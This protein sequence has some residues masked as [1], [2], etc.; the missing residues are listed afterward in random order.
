MKRI[1]RRYLALHLDSMVSPTRRE[2]I[3]AIWNSVTK[4]YGE[5]GASLANLKLIDYDAEKKIAVIRTALTSLGMVRTA[6][7]SITSIS[8]KD[9]AVHVRSVS[10]TIKSLREKLE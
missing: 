6:V 4:L 5:H 8:N 9:T 10:G 1:K 3:D 2:I 7:A